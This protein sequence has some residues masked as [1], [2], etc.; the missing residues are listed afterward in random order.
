MVK[1]Y[2]LP[3]RDLLSTIIISV[4][5][6]SPNITINKLVHL[7][8]SKSNLSSIIGS[9]VVVMFNVSSVLFEMFIFT[10]ILY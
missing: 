2:L 6:T 7:Q 4:L 3:I 9:G 10:L 5:V 8:I 1:R